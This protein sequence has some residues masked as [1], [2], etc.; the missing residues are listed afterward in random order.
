MN[1][2]IR[3]FAL[4]VAIAGLACSTLAPINPKVRF[5]HSTVAATDPGPLI[6][7][8]GPITCQSVN[9]CFVPPTTSR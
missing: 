1:N 5:S 4:F 8:P 7:V 6:T 3:F 9:A 2:M